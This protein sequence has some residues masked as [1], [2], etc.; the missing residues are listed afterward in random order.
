MLREEFVGAVRGVQPLVRYVR[1]SSHVGIPL[2]L[3]FLL[4]ATFWLLVAG[5]AFLY[6]SLL[7][8]FCPGKLVIW[9]QHVG[10]S[11]SAWYCFWQFVLNWKSRLESR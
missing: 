6:A 10:I 5:H 8:S 2:A 7:I 11:N 3:W 9:D 4:L 1:C